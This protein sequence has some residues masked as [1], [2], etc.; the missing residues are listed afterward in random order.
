MPLVVRV[1]G[2][3]IEVELL[4]NECF[5]RVAGQKIENSVP[6]V[7]PRLNVESVKPLDFGYV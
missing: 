2:V 7:V 3:K 1:L 4:P 6:D 5:G